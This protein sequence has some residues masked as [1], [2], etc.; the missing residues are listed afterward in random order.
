MSSKPIRHISPRQ[1]LAEWISQLI[2]R[3]ET[4][5]FF[6][7]KDLKV[8]FKTPLLGLAW[9]VFQ[10]LVYF[11]IILTA[12]QV[13]GRG[14]EHGLMPFALYLISG[15]TIWNFV[16]NVV[17]GAMNSVQSNAGIISKAYFPRFYLVLSP[18]IKGLLD[19]VVMMSI[20]FG[21]AAYLKQPF[22]LL[23][24]ILHLPLAIALSVGM[25]L[26]WAAIATSLVI[27]LPQT[28]HAIPILMYAMLFALP[29]FYDLQATG[30]ESLQWAHNL[31]PVAGAMDL[32]RTGF[33][34]FPTLPIQ[35]LG[36]TISILIWLL[37]GIGLFR[38]TERKMAD[39][40]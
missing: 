26:A 40:V 20:T 32:F 31:N 16:I 37:V 13:S 10:P 12:M 3:R 28:R 7:W 14:T 11:G 35:V 24:I 19:L 5:F 39:L 27:R 38:N 8:Q 30:S 25:S 6:V 9:S 4:L 22:D 2:Q 36:W 21:L 34:G 15:L 17:L 18:A 23:S 33:N 29:V 1:S